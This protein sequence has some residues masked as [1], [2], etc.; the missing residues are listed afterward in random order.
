MS[1]TFHFQRIAVLGAGVMGGK[2]AGG[3]MGPTFPTNEIAS[4][5]MRPVL[6]KPRFA[7]SVEK[8]T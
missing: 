8:L 5:M 7:P 6:D 1:S 3:P 2:A 4:D